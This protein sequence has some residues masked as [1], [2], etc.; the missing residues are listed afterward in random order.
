MNILSGR[1]L[2]ELPRNAYCQRYNWRCLKIKV[3]KLLKSQQMADRKMDNSSSVTGVELKLM[4]ILHGI[5]ASKA[6]E[7]SVDK[8]KQRGPIIQQPKN[9]CVIWNTVQLG[10]ALITNFE[11]TQNNARYSHVI[12]KD[13]ISVISY[14][15]LPNNRQ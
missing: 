8:T 7:L 10:R 13:V 4:A 14:I 12:L 1:S 5:V 3:Q 2:V 15:L 9:P 6:V 11:T